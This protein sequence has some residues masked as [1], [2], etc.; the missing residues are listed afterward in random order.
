MGG[1]APQWVFEASK[2]FHLSTTHSSMKETYQCWRS[3]M[4]WGCHIANAFQRSWAFPQ[5]RRKRPARSNSKRRS[6]KKLPSWGVQW[7]SN[8]HAP[9][10]TKRRKVRSKIRWFT[11]FCNSHYVSHF[12][13][14]FIDARAKRSIVESCFYDY[15]FTNN[16]LDAFQWHHS[17]KCE[18]KEYIGTRP[19]GGG[20]RVPTGCA[21]GV[22]WKL[23]IVSRSAQCPL[24][25]GQQHPQITSV[26]ILP[27]VHLRKPCYDFY[28]L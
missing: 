1:K 6:H 16:P 9:R 19:P 18:M 10:N 25:R 26:M 22:W 2:T 24:E 23:W 12:A 14:F 11:E 15:F 17:I 27:Q 5:P 28:F 21:Q 7:H 3:V 8:R 4:A 13:A 20:F